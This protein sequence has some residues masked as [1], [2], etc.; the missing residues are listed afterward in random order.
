[1]IVDGTTQGLDTSYT[2]NSFTAQSL[3]ILSSTLKNAR[4]IWLLENKNKKETRAGSRQLHS[5]V[6]PNIYRNLLQPVIHKNFK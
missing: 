4:K 2:V 1:M 5:T 6:T 3:L